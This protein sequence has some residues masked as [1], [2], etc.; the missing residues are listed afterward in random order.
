[1][2]VFFSST[3]RGIVSFHYGVFAPRRPL[4]SKYFELLYH[5]NAYRTIYAV[6]SNGMTVGLQNLS[7]QNFYNVR[8]VVPPVQ[9]QME[10][11]SFAEKATARLNDAIHA[12]QREIELLREYRTRLIADVVTGKLDVREAAA[13]LPDEAEEPEPLDDAETLAEGNEDGEGADLDVAPEEAEA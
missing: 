12:A 3:L 2:G 6:R 4:V 10:I 1:L 5:T 7:N 9:E 8:S 11:V 13:R